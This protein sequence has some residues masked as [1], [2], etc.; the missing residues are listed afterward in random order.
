MQA[1]GTWPP[2]L[3]LLLL[4]LLPSSE[5][6]DSARNCSLPLGPK[7][8]SCQSTWELQS[9]SDELT[10]IDHSG[11]NVNV[12]SYYQRHCEPR[13]EPPVGIIVGVTMGLALLLLAGGAVGT[14]LRIRRKR[15][16][17][18][19]E[20][21]PWKPSESSASSASVLQPRYSSRSLTT[22]SASPDPTSPAA[23]LYE[24]LF[25]D[26]QPRSQNSD[27]SHSR[28]A[29]PEPE[30]LYMNYE[31]S[32]RSEQPIYGNVDNVTCIP[33]RQMAPQPGAEDEDDYVVPGC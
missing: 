28:G 4:L 18:A 5:G 23:L 6:Q 19:P 31:G 25:L 1:A 11:N 2:L 8:C 9:C 20:P 17:A 22:P 32:S 29:S 26:S 13:G 30:D 33:D 12:T 15:G 10:C 14:V 21:C 3:L 27:P 7:N 16:S 24:N